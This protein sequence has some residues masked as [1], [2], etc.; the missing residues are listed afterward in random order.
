MKFF[1][2]IICCVGLIIL[3]VVLFSNFEV[4]AQ[5]ALQ[6]QKGLTL[7]PIRSELEITPGTSLDGTLTITNSTS[8]TMK[9]DL[10][11]ESF[12]VINQQY[13]YAF[14]SE[15]DMT[16]WV[17]F[18]E[19]SIELAAGQS[20]KSNYAIG[21]PLSAEPGGRYISLFASTDTHNNSNGS[22]I[23]SRQRVA[24]LLYI[25][26][27][28]EISRVGKLA[29]LSSPTVVMGESNWSMMLQNIGTTHFRSRYNIQIINPI[30]NQVISEN[31][32]DALVLPNSLR[33]VSSELPLPKLPGIYKAVYNIG[34][35]DTPAK[36]EVRYIIYLPIYAAI[37]ILGLIAVIFVL[38][39]LRKFYKIDI[40]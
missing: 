22:S 26:V 4:N 31:N 17:S 33:L 8:E 30:N 40:N 10:S 1:C 35:G 14:T 12:S 18:S 37:I 29:N 5:T 15:S 38:I 9:V 19:P 28:G 2:K 6:T 36:T 11:A 20:K 3:S 34:L 32:S 21:V 27:T 24:S 13:D 7:S 25:T 23:T 39:Y 16:K